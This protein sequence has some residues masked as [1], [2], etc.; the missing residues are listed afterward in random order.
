MT[1]YLI[2]LLGLDLS[3]ESLSAMTAFFTV[4]VA[5]LVLAGDNALI[6]GMVASQLQPQYRRKALFWG[7]VIAV[8]A[9]IL[10]SLVAVYLL[11][12]PGLQLVGGLL[13]LW[14]SW[15]LYTRIKKPK[16][17]DHS[18][19]LDEKAWWHRFYKPK[20]ATFAA[21]MINISIADISLSL[22][23]VLVVAGAALDH[24]YIMILGLVLSIA[25]LGAAATFIAK[26]M[27]KYKWLG[28]VGVVLIAIIGVQI[29]WHGIVALQQ[30][31]G[32][33]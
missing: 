6:I 8:V 20:N 32:M 15:N 28:L 17:K 19:S 24:P 25:L 13:L 14:I 12:V 16:V 27:E 33:A 11:K 22:D 2:S 26:L 30:F 10:M 5:D 31:F 29:S 18:K 7:M 3:P 23:N 21:A 9:R 1:D 4:I